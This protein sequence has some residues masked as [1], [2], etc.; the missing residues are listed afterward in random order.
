M[1]AC[2]SSRPGTELGDSPLSAGVGVGVQPGD[3]VKHDREEGEPRLKPRTD[4]T[5]E[6]ITPPRCAPQRKMK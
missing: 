2:A 4:S 5:N 3:K 1:C 6:E